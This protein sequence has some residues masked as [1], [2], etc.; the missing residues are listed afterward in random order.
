[1]DPQRRDA[2][3]RWR[4]FNDWEEAERARVPRDPARD[5][6]WFGEAWALARQT[7]PDWPTRDSQEEHWRRIARLRRGFAGLGQLP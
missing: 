7:N 4:I 6:R 1:M 5:L 3:A 2:R